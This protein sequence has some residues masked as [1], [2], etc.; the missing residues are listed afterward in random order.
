MV[1]P[2][3]GSYVFFVDTQDSV[4]ALKNVQWVYLGIAI[5]VF[6]LAFVFFISY[7]P[8]VTDADMEFQVQETH[9]A[10]SDKPF[11]KQYRLF[12]AAFAQF[13]YV[14]AQVAI[15][16]YFI[17]YAVETR[18]GTSSALAAKFLA[19]AQGAFTVGRFSGTLL[20]H[21]MR[22][23]WIFL[24]YLSGVV[25]F[26]AVATDTRDNVGL[27]MMFLVLFFESVCFPTIVALGIR[28]L[29]RHYKRGSGLIVAGVMGGACVPAL[30]GHVA[31]LRND[32]GFA[33]IVPEMVSLARVVSFYFSP[34]LSGIALSHGLCV[35]SSYPVFHCCYCLALLLSD[36]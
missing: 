33:M 2:V 30:T 24:V 32:T 1:G 10:G 6:V 31:D 18:P 7:I 16:T 26:L 36:D 12:H 20:M 14:G 3:L 13:T 5:F 11:R 19:G 35:M 15:A 34:N 25:I 23:R 8:E 21:L 27:S 29:G 9:V 4:Q 28:G 17:N 22:P